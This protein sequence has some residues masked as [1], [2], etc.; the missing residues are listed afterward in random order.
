MT[1]STNSF[2]AK[3]ITPIAAALVLALSGGNAEATALTDKLTTAYIPTLKTTD[4]AKVTP[5]QLLTAVSL[6]LQDPANNGITAQAIVAEALG[7]RKDKDKIAGQAIATAIAARNLSNNPALLGDLVEA[8][9][10]VG[11][12]KPFTATG[13]ANVVAAAL[14]AGT[15]ATGNEIGQGVAASFTN[16]S[17][18][19]N[20][21]TLISNTAKVLGKGTPAVQA[22][23]EQFVDGLFD[24][25]EVG[26]NDRRS[27][28]LT[29]AQKVAGA[30]PSA[31][32]ALYGGL[33]LNNPAG[34]F[35]S[36]A[37]LQ[38]LA[39]VIINDNKLT[40]AIG[41]IL[42]NSMGG[43][44]SL[45]TLAGTLKNDEPKDV[46]LIAQGLLRAGNS[47][48]DVTGILG[49]VGVPEAKARAKF[50]AVATVGTGDDVT[51]LSNIVNTLL[52]GTDAKQKNDI[53]LAVINAAGASAPVAGRGVVEGLALAGV[54]DAGRQAFGTAVVG[55]IKAFAAAGSMAAE[56]V[57]SAVTQ[58]QGNA[59]G[60]AAS[61]IS[62]G[63]K[64]AADIAREVSLTSAAGAP[65]AFAQ[66]LAGNSLA[67]K[68][69]QGIAVGVSVAY[70]AN[71]GD[72]TAAVITNSGGSD[73]AALAK[74]AT[75]SGAVANAVDEERTADIA[76]KVGAKMAATTSGAR[77][78]KAS[79]AAALATAL[80]KAIQTKPGVKLG[81]RMDEL[82]EM[83]AALTASLLGNG[84]TD[85]A[86][87]KLIAGIGSAV[88]KTLSKTTRLTGIT[89][90]GIPAEVAAGTTFAADLWEARD[91]A[92]SIAQAVQAS[93]LS[94]T[95]KAALLGS[96]NNT[97]AEQGPLL[98]A[99]LKLS[100][101][102][103]S[104]TYNAV[105]QAFTDVRAGNGAAKFEDGTVIVDETDTKNG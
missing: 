30:N 105:L 85:T 50:A 9:L 66:T 83:A 16:D 77:P 21:V 24:A 12:P 10:T 54:D 48:T 40:K 2:C 56:I 22:Q 8:V 41:E 36:D 65:V 35:S 47:T 80:A 72:I 6:A 42:A 28:T 71:A 19:K 44:T 5:E 103:G 63:S 13:Q 76:L 82:G 61:L 17:A 1:K 59:V 49:G 53:G 7:A 79:S 27:F 51:K 60:I 101:K 57:D 45:G 32:G 39:T 62:K 100:G 26:V 87:A 11:A 98:S 81:N 34:E 91:I 92:G 95:Q 25:N 23:F 99:F 3:R 20:L 46:A 73:K 69:T 38:A 86:Q 78:I 43:H 58:S 104:A 89:N 88:L 68:G 97:T 52:G 33:V 93:A 14:K 67:K 90:A 75:I 64:A 96:G 29:A 84:G 18:N 70:A 94:P 15:P 102:K 37:G 55:K 31:A 74:T 4:L